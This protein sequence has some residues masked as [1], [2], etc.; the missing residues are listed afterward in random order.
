[1]ASQG[2]DFWLIWPILYFPLAK[3]C[4]AFTPHP[5]SVIDHGKLISAQDIPNITTHIK[6]ELIIILDVS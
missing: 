6:C 5:V 2:P 4:L 1:M 3:S